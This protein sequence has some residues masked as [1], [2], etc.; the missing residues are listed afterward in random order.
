MIE[1]VKVEM[2]MMTVL[3]GVVSDRGHLLTCIL[4]PHLTCFRFVKVNQN[5][6][7]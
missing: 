3:K 2:A 7:K 6:Y 1:S 4:P 5:N